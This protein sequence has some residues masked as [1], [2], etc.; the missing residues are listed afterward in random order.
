MKGKEI[1]EVPLCAVCLIETELDALGSDAIVQQ[2]LR[3]IDKSDGGVTRRRWEARKKEQ[4][5]GAR[6]KKVRQVCPQQPGINK[7]ELISEQSPREDIIRTGGDGTKS[8][9]TDIGSEQNS[10]IWVNIFDPIDGASFKPNPTKPVPFFMQRSH[11]GDGAI[12]R[13]V[14]GIRPESSCPSIYRP[15]Q[16]DTS[17]QTLQPSSPSPAAP[18]RCS[19]PRV[20][21]RSKE[22]RGRNRSSR[23]SE[24]SSLLHDTGPLDWRYRGTG[25]SFVKEE[26]LKRPSSRFIPLPRGSDNSSSAY[27]TPPESP[28]L[29]PRPLS[30]PRSASPSAPPSVSP[31]ALVAQARIH[32]PSKAPQLSCEYLEQYRPRPGSAHTQEQSYNGRAETALRAATWKNLDSE[33]VGTKE[34]GR[35]KSVGA[36]V[37]RFFTGR[38]YSLLPARSG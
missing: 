1:T 23:S 35:M 37:R 2:G 10:T 16:S 17:Q 11:V 32:S 19:S 24:A 9:I 5:R 13:V 30:T 3:R 28:T 27:E 25:I 14:R 15:S 34:E 18:S 4:S 31:K 26:P 33:D 6:T 20:R 21:H 8:D 12:P 22:T 36:E 38:Q 29:Y 7:H